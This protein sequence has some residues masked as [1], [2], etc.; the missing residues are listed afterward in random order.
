MTKYHVEL[1]TDY[2]SSPVADVEAE[3]YITDDSWVTF[4]AAGKPVAMYSTRAV[5]SVT[6]K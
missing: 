1:D 4:K 6:A 3:G 2:A 5:V